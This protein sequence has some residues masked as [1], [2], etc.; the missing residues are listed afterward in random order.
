MES[1]WLWS[2]LKGIWGSEREG[3]V[4][5][6]NRNDIIFAELET[7]EGHLLNEYM[8]I[9]NSDYIR[10]ILDLVARKFK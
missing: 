7:E 8:Y 4:L 5:A 10:R 3:G 9:K 1:D 2:R 6:H